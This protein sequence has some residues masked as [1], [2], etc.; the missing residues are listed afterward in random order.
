[1]LAA[2]AEQFGFPEISGG[3]KV[4]EDAE[5]T[6]KAT[7]LLTGLVAAKEAG[8]DGAYQQVLGSIK[9]L[10]DAEDITN[11]M[12]AK[13]G[14]GTNTTGQVPR[15]ELVPGVQGPPTATGRYPEIA[16]FVGMESGRKPTTTNAPRIYGDILRDLDP[17][18]PGV[19][20]TPPS[21]LARSL[22]EGVAAALPTLVG[23]GAG[24]LVS[25]KLPKVI[26]P[27][28]KFVGDFWA[29]ATSR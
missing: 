4:L 29:G 13:L 23:P 1:M 8:D 24:Y 18:K 28:K 10:P 12:R 9:Q 6:K 20:T 25:K 26:K 14:E 3:L 2:T 7:G 11:K 5:T 21:N 19:Q 27:A 15:F 22:G 16:E 17:T